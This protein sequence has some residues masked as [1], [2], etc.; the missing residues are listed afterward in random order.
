MT[1]QNKP[2]NSGETL[3]N[4]MSLRANFLLKSGSVFGMG[5][6]FIKVLYFMA[7]ALYQLLWEVALL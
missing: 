2:K 1:P 3:P 7:Y 5:S 4:A 6:T